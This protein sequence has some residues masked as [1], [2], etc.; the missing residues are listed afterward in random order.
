MTT[1]TTTWTRVLDLDDLWEGEL[2]EVTVD[3]EELIL[4]HL[5]GGHVSAFRSACPHQG[6]SLADAFL[7][8]GALVCP[9]HL[10]EFDPRTGAGIN[11]DSAC[12]TA[13]PVRVEDDAIWV[14]RAA[15]TT[16]TE[17]GRG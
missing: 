7:E 3:G 6:S 10:W 9:M 16:D 8:E 17:G 13:R 5:E 14:G 11:P 12:L 1:D 4:V 15:T 2:V